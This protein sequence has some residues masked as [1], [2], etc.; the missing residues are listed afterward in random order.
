MS[1]VT[2]VPI[3]PLPR[4]TL[5]KL[6]LVIL[7]LCAAGAGLAWVGTAAFQPVSLSGGAMLRTLERG[8]G[9]KITPADAIALRYK[10]H[11][12]TLE[13]PVIQDSDESGRPFLATTADVYPGFAE[14]LQ[15]MQPGGRYILT[16]PPGTHQTG[17]V[18]PGAPFRV[19]DTLVFEIQVLQVA[20]GQASALQMQRMQEMMMQQQMQGQGAPGA[21]GGA[22]GAEGGGGAP[23]SGGGAPPAGARPAGAPP[24]G[25]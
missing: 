14:G 6:W 5:I 21:P 4:G 16:L 2:A 18:P 15:Q 1:E 17:Q 10:L 13:A 3:R 23:P 22:P 20:A 25:R 8:H 24:A 9:E 19:S 11:V 7:I 12:N